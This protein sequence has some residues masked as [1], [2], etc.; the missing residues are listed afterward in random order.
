MAKWGILTSFKD[1]P[2]MQALF[3]T[4]MD[5]FEPFES[6]PHLAVAV[7]GGA[8]SMALVLLTQE[9]VSAR[10]GKV[11]ALAVDHQLRSESGQEAHQVLKWL[12]D[13]GISTELLCWEDPKPTTRIQER[14]R[15]ARYNLLEN[16]CTSHKVRHLL[17]AHHEGD[18]WET[19]MQRLTRGSGIQGLRGIQAARCR[20]FGRL[21]R[22]LLEVNKVDLI[23]YLEQRGQAYIQDPS[24]ENL[25]FERVRWRQ[26]RKKYE[27]MGYTTDKITQIRQDACEKF[28]ILE[29]FMSQW[30][31]K[32]LEVSTY[33]YISLDWKAWVLLSREQ[34]HYLMKKILR[35][36]A[37]GDKEVHY[38]TPLKILDHIIDR[39]TGEVKG[40]R[41]AI[42][43]G[44]C[45]IVKREH[46]LLITR[47]S[48][49]LKPIVITGK[50]CRWDR[51]IVEFMND[52]FEGLSIEPLGTKR[53]IEWMNSGLIRQH[54]QDLPSYVLAS[55][56]CI[57]RQDD[58]L[59]LHNLPTNM[60]SSLS[61]RLCCYLG[62]YIYQA[63]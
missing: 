53:A 27:K 16:W 26:E 4:L 59:L 42:T 17:T 45:Y 18:Q 6:S 25:K 61:V 29:S 35:S 50:F 24:N 23:H 13:L 7:S 20:S 51:F 58:V 49:P 44:G 57:V 46:Q 31:L 22:P 5:R 14:A 43:I 11:T 30:I 48:R 32:N 2:L 33:G 62:R 39:L 15:R 34:K 28:V 9:W 41:K 36:M 38:P 21:L 52:R 55:L 12:T 47:E 37:L 56:P 63:T 3:S 19:M 10:G 8:D 1:N 54:M 40:D 60:E